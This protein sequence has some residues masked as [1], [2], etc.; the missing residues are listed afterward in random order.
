MSKNSLDLAIIGS[1]PAAITAAGDGALA[2]IEI[3]KFLQ[4][5]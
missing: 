2:A 5:N 3:I 1:G 4:K